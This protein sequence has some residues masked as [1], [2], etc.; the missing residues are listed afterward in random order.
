[1]Q[2]AAPYKRIGRAAF[3]GSA[4]RVGLGFVLAV[5]YAVS[6]RFGLTLAVEHPSVTLIWPPTGLALAAVLLWGPRLWPAIAAGAFVANVITAGSVATS[7]GIAAGN[8]LEALIAG[9]LVTRF[10]NG[11]D[12]FG[13]PDD[14]L[15]FAVLAGLVGTAV[16]ATCGV[17]SLV[18]GGYADWA[19][20]RSLWVTWWLG[21]AAAALVV[22]PP[23]VLWAANPRI[24]WS[25]Q[26]RWEAALALLLTA[27]VGEVLFGG[28]LQAST[29]AYPITF[30]S[31]PVLIW[32]AFRLGRRVTATALLVLSAMAIRGTLNGVGPFA[33]D[34]PNLDLLILQGYLWVHAVTA[35]VL[36]AALHER[37]AAER[38][39]EEHAVERVR[40]GEAL[41]A[42]SR[43]RELLLSVPDA[44]VIVDE[45]DRVAFANSRSE[46]LFGYPSGELI[47]QPVA[48][49]LPGS[50]RQPHSVDRAD[51]TVDPRAP[52][53]ELYGRRRDS[54][55]FPV[56][57]SVG[58]ISTDDGV[59]V[60]A[61]IRDITER[62]RADETRSLLEELVKS[63]SD[64]IYSRLLDGTVLTWNPGA[65]R[66]YGYSAEEMGG[67]SVFI[68]VPPHQHDD[69]PEIQDRLRRG[70]RIEAHETTRLT[71]DGRL[72]EISASISPLR[73]PAG[74]V[75]GGSVVA[76]DITEKK[77]AQEA[78]RVANQELEMFT[79]SVAHDLNTPLRGIRGLVDVLLEDYGKVLG[80]TGGEYARRLRLAVDR[81]HLLALGL[82][83]YSRVSGA[84]LP[85]RHVEL[86]GVVAEALA[87]LEPEIKLRSACIDVSPGLPGLPLALAHEAVLTQIMGNLVS[88]AIKFVAPGVIPVVRIRAEEKLRRVRL[89]VEDNGIGIEP[90]Y[91]PR[92]FHA[93]ERLHDRDTYPG[94]GLGL[95][96]V[97]K[98]VERMHGRIGVE[99]KL[100]R[101]T[102]F[103]IELQKEC[104]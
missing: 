19:Q 45:Q 32:T 90:Q 80:E 99:S 35:L 59:L 104:A 2:L 49:L 87:Q 3:D 7:L 4:I 69:I 28:Q 53:P 33:A 98:G 24:R 23:L 50:W 20:Y 10:A 71:K 52:Q 12:A 93:F 38:E 86:D 94:T 26:R 1:V 51:R 63:S 54:S 15:R 31:L 76:R 73:D 57:I 64:A 5:V 88:N 40:A 36:A 68:L 103:W 102:R 77:R 82:L 34:S 97:S 6:A 75:I 84:P 41:K 78:L 91:L 46:S 22:T 67:K 8:T 65:E 18:L 25:L 58:Q 81:L 96:I 9:Y 43:F 56:E 70:E 37:A 85:L 29:G 42:E 21:D 16:S 66:I 60:S 61:A 83:D 92:I 14:V 72:V 100:G 47:G 13:R 55:E 79:Y 27:A 95:A 11:R 48:L 39:R 74:R 17:T 89:C 30:L 101:G 62:K 44:M